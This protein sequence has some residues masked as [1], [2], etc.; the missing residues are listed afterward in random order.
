MFL[1]NFWLFLKFLRSCAI[2][3]DFCQ[4]V[5]QQISLWKTLCSRIRGWKN[6]YELVMASVLIIYKIILWARQNFGHT[7]N[8]GYRWSYQ[9]KHDW[10]E[11]RNSEKCKILPKPA[12]TMD[13]LKNSALKPWNEPFSLS[14]LCLS[15]TQAS[16]DHGAE[17]NCS[18]RRG[19]NYIQL[20]RMGV[21]PK[22][23]WVCTHFQQLFGLVYQRY[24]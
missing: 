20:G 22:K 14:L 21:L 10:T 3:S 8:E 15:R 23:D 17:P 2:F 6:C 19:A 18:Y 4:F 24:P 5:P 13:F 11:K 12:R 16:P 9:G 7:R 1:G